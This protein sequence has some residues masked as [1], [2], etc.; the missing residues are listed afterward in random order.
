MGRCLC[1]TYIIR[2]KKLIRVTGCIKVYVYPGFGLKRIKEIFAHE[3]SHLKDY[4]EY[5]L[6]GYRIPRGKEKR[7]EEW[8]RIFEN[9]EKIVP[10]K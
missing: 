4:R 7:A 6:R 1:T 8:Q 2:N 10:D 5:T 3:C 9:E